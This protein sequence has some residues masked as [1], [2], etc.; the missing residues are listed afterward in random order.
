MLIV[1][2]SKHRSSPPGQG[3]S[4]GGGTEAGRRGEVLN[5]TRHNIYS[6]CKLKNASHYTNV[7][8]LFVIANVGLQTHS[9]VKHSL[10]NT[11]YQSK[12]L[13]NACFLNDSGVVFFSLN[14]ISHC[15]YLQCLTKSRTGA[16]TLNPRKHCAWTIKG[17]SFMFTTKILMLVSKKTYSANKPYKITS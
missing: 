5:V 14:L 11:K 10:Q 1:G 8:T 12:M 17:L 6:S 9:S 13:R 2:S 3:W 7:N 4:G 15:W 16:A